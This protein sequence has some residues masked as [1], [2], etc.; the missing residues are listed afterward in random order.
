MTTYS[1]YWIDRGDPLLQRG[2]T[3]TN[4]W[5]EPRVVVW[6]YARASAFNDPTKIPSWM[7]PHSKPVYFPLVWNFAR[8]RFE[9]SSSGQTVGVNHIGDSYPQIFCIL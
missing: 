9:V 1:Y 2:T 5:D 8:V 7:T 6:P 3:Y 4:C